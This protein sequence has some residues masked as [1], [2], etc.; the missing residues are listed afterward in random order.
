MYIS[1]LERER[2]LK[3]LKERVR[4]L[5]DEVTSAQRQTRQVFAR[6]VRA[7]IEADKVQVLEQLSQTKNNLEEQIQMKDEARIAAEQ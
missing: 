6:A 2:E 1:H 4:Q 5:E 7:E 3:A